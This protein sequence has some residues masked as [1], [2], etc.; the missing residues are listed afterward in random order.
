M[1]TIKNENS[2]LLLLLIFIAV[3]SAYVINIEGPSHPRKIIVAGDGC[4]HFD[5][6]P[7]II[8]YHTV[9]FNKVFSI[10][11]TRQSK[12]YMGHYFHKVDNVVINKYTSGTSLMILPFY[13]I[14]YLITVW[15]GL[16]LDGFG[17]FFQYSTV[18]AAIFWL[19][20]GIWYCIK[21]LKLYGVSTR[22]ATLYVL[23]LLFGTNLF[24]YAFVAPAFSHVYSFATFSILLFIVKKYFLNNKTKLL[25][26]AAFIYGLLI[27]I[28]PVNAIAIFA[29][30]ILAVSKNN[31][32][33]GLRYALKPHK[34]IISFLLFFLA[35]SPQIIINILQTGKPFFNGY[36]NE[37]F[38]F[39]HPQIIN[40]L[41]SYRKG[42]LVYTPVMLLLIPA[43][44][45]WYR[46]NRFGFKVFIL[47][48]LLQIYIFSAWWNWFYGDSFGMRPMVDYYAF[49][50][51]VISLYINNIKK[52]KTKIFIAIV[53]LFVIFL[54]TFQTYQ[55]AEGILRPDSMNK[56]AY[57]YIFLKSNR[58]YKNIV[59]G[60]DESFYGHLNNRPFL[61]TKYATD[62]TAKGWSDAPVKVKD[63]NGSGKRVAVLNRRYLYSPTFVQHLS[64]TLAGKS[65]IYVIFKT[66]YFESLK[67]EALHAYFVVN[68]LDK[69]GKKTRFYKL[70]RIKRLP[71]NKINE[72]QNAH[73]GFKLPPLSKNDKIVKYYIW[74]RGKHL[75]YIDNL[76]LDFYTWKR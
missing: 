49:Y 56:K 73:I 51:I 18:F 42:W 28:R 48:F 53:V 41:F 25:Y 20:A 65:N 5:Y 39:L 13:M 43:L 38:Y 4:G 23:I 16:P 10:E 71:D 7:S 27:L 17:L 47:F 67:N 29:L 59:S 34:I 54:N 68:I 15:S 12:S 64:D 24:F 21:L 6:L 3:I 33:T 60:C 22:K 58:K 74:Y 76:K 61:S 44:F 31:F 75:L 35:F 30:P 70:F 14:A 32:I 8:I 46:E 72:W 11:K 69:T 19:I 55:Y 40:F 2:T 1:Q 37:G 57:W 62:G 63:P 36:I 45:Y 9:N 50:F 26:V 66:S 52:I